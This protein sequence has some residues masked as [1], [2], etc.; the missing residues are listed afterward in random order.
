MKAGHYAI[1]VLFALSLLPFLYVVA[2]LS[3]V[4]LVSP[5]WNPRVSAR[6]A[7]GGE[8]SVAFFGPIQ[9]ADRWLRPNHWRAEIW[10]DDSFEQ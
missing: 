4:E 7:I 1:A 8:M 9:A 6:Y 2:Y 10:I 3:L 5:G